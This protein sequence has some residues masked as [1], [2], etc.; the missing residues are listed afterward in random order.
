MPA[1]GVSDPL[2][3]DEASHAVADAYFAHELHPLTRSTAGNVAV[4]GAEIGPVRIVHLGWGAP[5]TVDTTHPGGYA[6][7]TPVSGHLE[8]L[9][10]HHELVATPDC[11]AIYPPD[12]PTCL[13][14]WSASLS[15]VGVRFD[16]DYLH[17]EMSRLLAISA[18]PGYARICCA[19]PTG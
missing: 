5:V 4:Q 19:E 15:V 14:R 11:A 7:N 16:R 17:R 8:S 12:T 10:G 9:I 1:P 3:W 2:D 13:R 18:W 6:V